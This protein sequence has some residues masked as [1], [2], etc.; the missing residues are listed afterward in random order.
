MPK[1]NIENREFCFGNL[2]K[3]LQ[4]SFPKKLTQVQTIRK[5]YEIMPVESYR[6]EPIEAASANYLFHG[7]TK[8]N[9]YIR[10]A[11]IY[12]L[13]S[14]TTQLKLI[15]SAV[16]T[17]LLDGMTTVS[18][19]FFLENL[20]LMVLKLT[21]DDFNLKQ[22][23][24]VNFDTDAERTVEFISKCVL[25]SLIMNPKS[26]KTG[27]SVI[28]HK[29]PDDLIHYDPHTL[30]EESSGSNAVS[31]SLQDEQGLQLSQYYSFEDCLD[32]LCAGNAVITGITVDASGFAVSVSFMYGSNYRLEKLVTE[33]Q[34]QEAYE[35]LKVNIQKIPLF[36]GKMDWNGQNLYDM[37]YRGLLSRKWTAY[38]YYRGEQIVAILDYKIRENGTVELG[39]QLAASEKEYELFERSLIYLMKLKFYN[40]RLFV[41]T[42]EE[43][44]QMRNLFEQTGFLPNLYLDLETGIRTNIISDRVID[45]EEGIFSNSVYYYSYSLIE[46]GLARKTH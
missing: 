4:V 5:L 40:S 6:Y 32:F 19:I 7:K 17:R 14:D 46:N 44:T 21:F 45:K 38:A 33:E 26:I 37:V 23:L 3:I 15:Y 20:K 30:F 41:G 8:V 27:Q 13:T 18:K 12:H 25:W 2:C 28:L 24:N 11:A 43:N 39:V 34:Y 1:T 35:F 31:I 36:H 42:Y 16:K 10:D 29:I 9:A 22:Y